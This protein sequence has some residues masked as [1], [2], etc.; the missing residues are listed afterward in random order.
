[1]SIRKFLLIVLF[2]IP[3]ALY[4]WLLLGP[5]GNLIDGPRRRG[6]VF[7]VMTIVVTAVLIRYKKMEWFPASLMVLVSY[8]AFYKTATFISDVSTFP[9]SLG[10]SE[11]SRY[12]YAS[13]FFSDRLYHLSVPPS[14]LHPSR[15]LM[16]AVPF[17][18]PGLPLWLHRLWQVLLWVGFT[19]GAGFALSRRLKQSWV[20]ALWAFLFLLQGPVYYHLLVM[21]IVVLWGIKP[22]Q[23]WYSLVVVLVASAWAGISRVNWFPVPGILGAAL[24]LLEVPIEKKPIWRYSVL[25]AVWILLGTGMA[26]LTQRLYIFWSGNPPDQFGSGFT[27]DLLWYRLHPSPT[28]PGGILR[29]L[30]W[31]MLPLLLILIVRMWFW[32]RQVHW[33][34]KLGIWAGLTVLFIIGL[35]VSVKIG[36]G[37]NL[38]NM[39][40]FLVLLMIAGSYFYFE[41]FGKETAEVPGVQRPLKALVYFAVV[42][43][44]FFAITSGGQPPARDF[45]AAEKDLILLQDRLQ[46]IAQKNGKIL[47]ID[48]RH[49]LTFGYLKD[50]PL[51]P[52]YEVVFLM[53]MV[54][55]GNRAYLDK[56]FADMKAQ[57]FA[58]IV[59]GEQPTTL[60]GRAYAFGEEN[61]AWVKEVAEPLLCYYE[62]SF[63][64]EPMNLVVY[65]PRATPCQ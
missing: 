20:L 65:L 47:L 49:L 1:M 39:D 40:A 42:V 3:I 11:G 61:D 48:Q 13:L 18:I 53:E 64:L 24:Y 27:S 34:R 10:W 2:L 37:S 54:M 46:P 33:L 44:I 26:F 45:I 57:R 4:T 56:F 30:I 63:E 6:V 22:K 23:T 59:S 12:Y 38:H 19:L 43:P 21:V 15:Y 51:T 29:N 31:V 35:I 25:P 32:R 60:Q 16:Q 5:Y 52:D 62:K 28:Y 14:V 9:F 36:G 17:L 7:L 50:L 8:A 55:S 58:A 41:K